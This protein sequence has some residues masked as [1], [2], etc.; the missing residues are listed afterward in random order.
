MT[1]KK[2]KNP[3]ITSIV[4]RDGTTAPFDEKKIA[5]AV[6][7]AMKAAG[8]LKAGAPEEVAKAVEKNV[9]AKKSIDKSYSPTVEGVQDEVEKELM[10]LGFPATA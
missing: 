10:A 7:K 2:R 5:I 4:K 6:E 8:E 3:G 9:A 1:L